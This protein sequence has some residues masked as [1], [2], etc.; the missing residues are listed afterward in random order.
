MAN[1]LHEL[2]CAKFVLVV[3]LSVHLVCVSSFSS[4]RGITSSEICIGIG[5]SPSTKIGQGASEWVLRATGDE[6]KDVKAPKKS[7]EEI[8]KQAKRNWDFDPTLPY[9]EQVSKIYEVDNKT[10]ALFSSLFKIT[11]SCPSLDR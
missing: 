5:L 9:E 1:I 6:R 7:L 2:F 10:T 11:C 4:R 8:K 3:L